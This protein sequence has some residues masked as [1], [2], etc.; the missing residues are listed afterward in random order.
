ANVQPI[1][2]ITP[3]QVTLPGGPLANQTK[4]TVTIMV[5][6]TNMVKLSDATVVGAKD[7]D[8]Q[9]AEPQPGKVFSASLSFPQGFQIEQGQQVKFTA[10]TTPPKFPVIK[11]PL[12]Q[13]APPPQPASAPVKAPPS[14][15]VPPP[16]PVPPVAHAP[17][18]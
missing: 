4:P 2:S 3:P 1:I 6:G 10:K 5:N 15:Q 13:M 14:S 7:V 18:H 11:V 16:P 9:L 12:I 17:A 8:V